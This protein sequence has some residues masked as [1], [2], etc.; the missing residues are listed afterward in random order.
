MF[1]K[2]EN[3]MF[4]LVIF[5]VSLFGCTQT[6][7]E[8]EVRKL[9]GLTLLKSTEEPF[10]GTVLEYYNN[11]QKKEER[12]YKDGKLHGTWTEWYENG[13]ILAKGEFTEGEGIWTMFYENGQKK[14]QIIQLDKG[15][16]ETRWHENGKRE[17]HREGVFE[18]WYEYY[19]NGQQREISSMI[20]GKPNGTWTKWYENG[21]KK[22]EVNF[23]GGKLHGTRTSWDEKGQKVN[24][25]YFENGVQVPKP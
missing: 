7:N 3:Q 15:D 8:E 18:R 17:Y 23:K 19:P 21:Q 13:K 22:S 12:N 25:G 10:T 24:E 4:Y 14:M 11:E 2:M 5:I 1:N 16:G 6:V 9:A 20:E